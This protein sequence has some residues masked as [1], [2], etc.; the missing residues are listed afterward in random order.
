MTTVLK[1]TIRDNINKDC[2]IEVIINSNNNV[3]IRQGD[4]D[5]SQSIIL[6]PQMAKDLV[7]VL[8]NMLKEDNDQQ[9]ITLW[10]GQNQNHKT[11][12]LG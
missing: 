10:Y 7:Y 8:Q 4:T 3:V 5:R 11:T 12:I 9:P 1:C 2:V 6:S